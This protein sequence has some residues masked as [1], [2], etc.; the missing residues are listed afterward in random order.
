MR[1]PARLR[2]QIQLDPDPAFP[3]PVIDAGTLLTYKSPTPLSRGVYY[4]HVRTVD[5]AG[6][7]SEWSETR[8]FTIVAGVTAPPLPTQT[9]IPTDVPIEPTDEV[10]VEPTLEPTAEPTVEP[11]SEPT[12][13]HRRTHGRTNQCARSVAARRRVG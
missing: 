7:V 1:W 10:I 9:P 2:Y 4:W 5:K 13:N 8:S 6:N 11:T 3:L 12:A